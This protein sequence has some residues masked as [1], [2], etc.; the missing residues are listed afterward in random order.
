MVNIDLL[1]SVTIM[2]GENLVVVCNITGKPSPQVT[3]TK[4][5][6]ALAQSSRVSILTEGLD[7][8]NYTLRSTLAVS[9]A[10]G[11][12]TGLYTCTGTNTLPNSNIITSSDSSTV[13]VM[14]SKHSMLKM[15]NYYFYLYSQCKK[16]YRSSAQLYFDW[17]RLGVA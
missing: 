10:T 13:T 6:T 3:W 1:P 8:N 17:S 2:Y 7:S 14:E 12:D 16:S 9:V 15:L 5:G 11:G 4:D